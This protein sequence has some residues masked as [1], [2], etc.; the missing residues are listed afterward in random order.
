MRRCGSSPARN[1][2]ARMRNA[3]FSFGLRDSR[4]W[5]WIA[6]AALAFV[7]GVW[8]P[9]YQLRSQVLIDDE[10]HAVRMLVGADAAT[11]AT[12]F[13][14]ADYCIPLTLY[15][16]WLFDLGVLD[17][18]QMHLPLLIAGVALLLVAPS[19]LRRSVALPVRAVW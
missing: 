7:A 9:I 16:R 3:D 10:W 14:Y 15:Y 2:D 5:P 8:L 4:S 11:I 18:W 12:H 1:A 17:E 6:L 19:L 13:G